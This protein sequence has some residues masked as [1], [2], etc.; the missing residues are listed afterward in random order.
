MLGT[1]SLEVKE[2]FL[3]AEE[4]AHF[5]FFCVEICFVV[6]VVADFEGN[7]INNFEVESSQSHEFAGIVCH[8]TDAVESEVGQDLRADP[9]FSQISVKTQG[10][11]GFY[12]VHSLFLLFVSEKFIFQS[13]PPALLMEI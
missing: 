9:V 8:Q 13:N 6:F 12:G 3:M 10:F 1:K 2:T 7:S 4:V 11:I 5:C